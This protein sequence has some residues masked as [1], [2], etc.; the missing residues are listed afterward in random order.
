MHEHTPSEFLKR[1][2]VEFWAR[3]DRKTG[4]GKEEIKRE[5]NEALVHVS[6]E[7]MAK[8]PQPEKGEE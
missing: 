7:M 3:L 6:L 2:R 4:W 8:L 1:F 5:F